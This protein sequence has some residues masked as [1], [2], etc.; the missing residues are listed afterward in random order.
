[1]PT[2][3]G[4]V[5]ETKAVV[6]THTC[7]GCGAVACF[8]TGVKMKQ[9]FKILTK[10]T[11]EKAQKMMGKWFCGKCKGELDVKINSLP[12]NFAPQAKLL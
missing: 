6:F 8:G 9:A 2:K 5:R 4:R 10:D 12:S 11:V 1:M 3:I 7:E